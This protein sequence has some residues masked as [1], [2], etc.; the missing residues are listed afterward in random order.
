MTTISVG[1]LGCGT[2][3]SGVLTLLNRG[4]NQIAES[5]GVHFNIKKIAVKHPDKK[6]GLNI[7][8]DVS[9]TGEIENVINDPS[10]QIVI[11]VMGTLDQAYKAIQQAITNGKSVITA[12]KEL[13]ALKGPQLTKLAH[14]N[15]VDLYYEASVAG[16]IPILRVLNESLITDQITG[17]TGIVNGTSNFVLSA[18][19]TDHSSYEESLKQ[20]QSLGYAEANPIKDIEGIDAAYKLSILS[21]LAFG[22]SINLKQLKRKGI[23]G[24]T[25]NDING[26]EALGLTIKPAVIARKKD[27]ELFTLVGPVAVYKQNPLANVNG[28]ENSVLVTSTALGT[29]SYSGPGAGSEPTANSVMSDL[30]AVTKHI[31]LEQIGTSFNKT[32]D[33]IGESSLMNL[34]LTY[35]L[36]LN[37]FTGDKAKIS[38]KNYEYL[39][40]VVKVNHAYF[41]VTKLLTK[42]QKNELTSALANGVTEVHFYPILK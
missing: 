2:V 42:E 19:K 14:D 32:T 5:L 17:L 27:H 39:K 10:I 41:C 1:M 35:F 8:K 38:P 9:F 26:A 33:D 4:A 6:R 37:S 23:E 3:G 34:P 20:A 12:N 15:H 28:V 40:Q 18:M 36:T 24:V 13:I 16:G 21:Q 31:L 29:T 11:E 30:L 7:T 25:S 22:H